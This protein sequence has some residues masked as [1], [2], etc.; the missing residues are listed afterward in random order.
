M[1]VILLGVLVTSLFYIIFY[2]L[3]R[4]LKRLN[5][6]REKID[7]K[8]VVQ[9]LQMPC[10]HILLFFCVVSCII[11]TAYETESLAETR[12]LIPLYEDEEIKQEKNENNNQEKLVY[13]RLTDA[14][15]YEYRFD[16]GYGFN[17][18]YGFLEIKDDIKIFKNSNQAPQI[19]IYKAKPKP[20]F[21]TLGIWGKK[22]IR[23]EIYIPNSEIE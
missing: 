11:P 21:Y 7:M 15:K 13:L 3:F 9:I 17:N 14:L 2:E 8:N 19:L 22:Q 10:F 5:V 23:Y 6:F 12:K 16:K 18:D 1:L 20:S 4:N